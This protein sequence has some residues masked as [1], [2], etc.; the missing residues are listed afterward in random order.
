MTARAYE[1]DGLVMDRRSEDYSPSPSFVVSKDANGN[2]MSRMEDMN[3]NMTTLHSRGEATIL[4]FNFWRVSSLTRQQELL[5][6]EC[7]RLLY[8]VF[9][10][11]DPDM[12]VQT[13]QGY[14]RMLRSMAVYCH[15]RSSTVASLL[16]DAKAAE[17]FALTSG[18][19]AVRQ[20]LSIVGKLRQLDSKKTG[21]VCYETKLEYPIRKIRRD[22]LND[23][24][25]HA[26]IPTRLYENLMTGLASELDQYEAIEQE[27]LQTLRLVSS[28]NRIGRACSTQKKRACG[29]WREE[30]LEDEFRDIASQELCTY[31]SNQGCKATVSGLVSVVT[32]VQFVCKLTIHVFSGMR[33]SEGRYLPYDCYTSTVIDGTRYHLIC[34]TTTK[35][36][37]GIPKGVYWVTG[38]EGKRAIA[39]AQRICDVVS[40]SPHCN[41]PAG[42]RAQ[43]PLFLSAGYCYNRASAI[44]ARPGT[45]DINSHRELLHRFGLYITNEDIAELE[46][47]DPHRA[48]WCEDEFGVGKCWPL[49]THQM[50]R[51]LALYATGSGLVERST[52]RRQLQHITAAMS[53]YYSRGSEGAKDLLKPAFHHMCAV[54]QETSSESEALS[55]IRN[56]LLNE[57]PMLGPMGT[58]ARKNVMEEGVLTFRARE[59]VVHGFK[60]GKISYRSTYLGGCSETGP[61]KRRSMRSLVSCLSCG[62][63]GIKLSRLDSA[64]KEQE[65]LVQ[66]TREGSVERNAEQRTLEDLVAARK[67]LVNK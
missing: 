40:T 52:L 11:A 12:A 30:D 18:Y 55:Y 27:L 48:W 57:E 17:V 39:I 62:K 22:F 13:L 43:V 19:T 60:N 35:L 36:E 23:E 66:R 25:Q 37:N 16:A 51:S 2:V 54:Y 3:W 29:S 53:E 46:E 47:I 44:G 45:L 4:D 61:C 1:N 67:R 9:W 21:Y 41:L 64:I 56:V 32:Q 5:I 31:L 6:A 10:I 14:F 24:K 50:R 26:P 15:R 59:E 33:D 58:W 65:V 38:P 28:N 63:A 8:L 42:G 49:R 34:G 20:L 7:K